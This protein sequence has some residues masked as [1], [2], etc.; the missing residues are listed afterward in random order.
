MSVRYFLY[1][2][3]YINLISNNTHTGESREALEY[4]WKL[5][6]RHASKLF[7]VRQDVHINLSL[8]EIA[9]LWQVVRGVR[10]F[11]LFSCFNITKRHSKFFKSLTPQEVHLKINVVRI[12]TQ[13]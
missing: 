1:S 2:P 4:V 7:Q 8:N 5:A 12:H 3:T 13:L 9:E 11:S 10:A 6:Q